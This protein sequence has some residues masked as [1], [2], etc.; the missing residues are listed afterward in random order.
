MHYSKLTIAFTLVIF[1]CLVGLTVAYGQ[2]SVLS[3]GIWLKAG[4]NKT[5]VYRVTQAQLKNAG[6]D[7]NSIDPRTIKVYTNPGGMLP[8]PNATSRPVDLLQSAIMVQGEN[9]GVFNSSDVI[10]FYAQGPDKQSFSRQKEIFA[11]EQNLYTGKNFVFI[12]FGGDRGKRLSQAPS[13][14]STAL[15]N[16]FQ[17]VIHHELTSTNILKSGR[18]WFGERFE[19]NTQQSIRFQA[20][21]IMPGTSLKLVSDVVAYSLAGAAFTLNFNNVAIN[22][23]FVPQVPNS[24]YGIKARHK[25]DTFLINANDVGAGSRAEQELRYSFTRNGSGSAYGHLDFF[26]LTFT[27][28]LAAYGEQTA[29]RSLQSLQQ[30]V[31]RFAIERVS[32]AAQVW[33]V[34][35]PINAMN[36]ALQVSNGVA[37]FTAN[38]EALEEFIVFNVPLPTEALVKVNNQ[39]LRGMG[40]ATLLIVTDDELRTAAQR[41]ADHRISYT[42]I[43]SRVVT[44]NEIFNEFSGGRPDVVAIRDVARY[45]KQRYPQEFKYLLLFGKGTYDYKNVLP[46]NFNR[47]LTYESRNSVSPLETYSSDDFFALLEDNE[48]EWREC[49]ACNETMDIGVGRIPAKHLQQ[50]N[51]MVDKIIDYETRQSLMGS[52]QTKITFVADDGD[53]NVHQAQADLLASQ[54]ETG[55]SSVFSAE[56]IY[57]DGFTQISRPAGQLAP[58]AR[59]AIQNAFESGALVINYTGHGNEYQWAAEKVLDELMILDLENDRLPFLVTATCEF[60]RHDDGQVTSAAEIILLREKHGVVGL[61]TTARPVNSSTNFNL[62]KAFY[63]AFLEK[64]NEQFRSLG[65]IFRDTKNNSLSGVAN[66][67]FSLLGDPSMQLAFPQER[68]KITSLSTDQ[69]TDTLQA[70]SLV[71]VRGYVDGGSGQADQNFN[72]LLEAAVYDKASLVRTLGNENPPFSYRQWSS[73]IFK[74]HANV[75][76][77]EFEFNF[78]VPKNIAYAMGDGRLTIFA[79]AENKTAAGVEAFKIGGSAGMIIPDNQSPV[80]SVFMNDET[81]VNG[82]I[83][84]S[85]AKLL[86]RLNDQSG[87]TISNYG[88]GNDLVA[89]LDDDIVFELGEFY[90]AEA[91]DFTQGRV[92]FPLRDLSPGKHRIKVLAWDTH[93][94]PAEA[95]VDFVV[96][97]GETMVIEEFGNFPNPFAE[98]TQLFFTHNTA[99]EDLVAEWVLYG[100]QGQQI[101]K[102]SIPALNSP[103]RV[104]LSALKRNDLV[105]GIYVARLF[106]RSE[107]TGKR[108]TAQAK[109]IILN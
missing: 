21:G 85:D 52:W 40:A 12:T 74:G 48:G 24:Q 16:T 41:L 107:S 4:I 8:Q 19:N 109:L 96:T 63:D 103:F 33:N 73:L 7:V 9:D 39:N 13:L 18:E 68:I 64:E 62:N 55:N 20:E 86:V 5:G 72:G 49:F 11:Y 56:K 79:R 80:V 99:G 66:R 69:Q 83:V 34:S 91:D 30:S 108:A 51:H 70:L 28:K 58:E 44:V 23:Q 47:V 31:S 101:L 100:P 98:E 29:F 88:I 46:N 105:A 92:V 10:L 53:F 87:I 25:R 81:F 2:S 6:I 93:N 36:Y 61:V 104:D 78:R 95:T 84:S 65:D 38:T 22:E 59:R 43:E 32:S 90:L 67:N 94:N 57:I 102:E 17:E 1:S 97:D 77:G 75:K 3:Q 50:A 106:V 35:D 82:G 27:R 89:I 76:A 45:V 42:G 71:T 15:V 14:T 26:T 54:V 60:G 37:E